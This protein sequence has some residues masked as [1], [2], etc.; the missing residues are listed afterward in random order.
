MDLS[1][2]S[3]ESMQARGANAF[4]K[5]VAIDAHGMNYGSPAIEDWQIGWRA[6]RDQRLQERFEQATR[7]QAQVCMA[8]VAQ[9]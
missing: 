8:E 1:I 6:R 5:G 4:D 9:P 7:P 2:F 3:R